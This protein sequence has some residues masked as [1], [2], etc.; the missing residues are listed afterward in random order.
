MTVQEVF[1]ILTEEF[2]KWHETFVAGF[3]SHGAHCCSCAPYQYGSEIVI[4]KSIT[5]IQDTPKRKFTKYG[6][7]MVLE[8]S[9][10]TTIATRLVSYRIQNFR[11]LDL[12]SRRKRK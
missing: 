9:L 8:L 10:R 4:D 1:D 11:N 3:D 7:R 2:N 5:G 6:K 12:N